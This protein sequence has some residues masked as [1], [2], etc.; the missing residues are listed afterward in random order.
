MLSKHGFY[1]YSLDS[2]IHYQRGYVNEA[3]SMLPFCENL[4]NTVISL[5]KYE[6]ER[7]NSTMCKLLS[8][9]F[10]KGSLKSFNKKCFKIAKS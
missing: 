7:L 10:A 6:L 5:S 2:E 9:T 4:E 8:R 3:I 1:A